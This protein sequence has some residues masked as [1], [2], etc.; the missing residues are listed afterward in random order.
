MI[1]VATG[2]HTS[3]ASR[4]YTAH[5]CMYFLSDSVDYTDDSAVALNGEL[6]CKSANDGNS[7]RRVKSGSFCLTRYFNKETD[8]KIG[9]TVSN[10][11]SVTLINDDGG[12]DNFDFTRRCK[13]YLNIVSGA[14]TYECPLGVFRF[15]KPV[16]QKTEFISVTGYDIMQELD[17]IA[18]SWWNSIDFTNGVTLSTLASSLATQVGMTLQTSGIVN[19]SESMTESPFTAVEMTYR[20]ILAM[21]CEAMG[22][23]G[24]IAPSGHL[25]LAGFETVSSSTFSIDV[26]TSPNGV[27]SIDI[28]EYSTPVIDKLRVLA[29][30]SA[31]SITIGSGTNTYDIVNNPFLFSATPADLSRKATAIYN[32]INGFSAYYPVSVKAAMDWSIEPGDI[33]SMTYG[34][35][36]YQTPIFQQTL[37]WNGGLVFIDFYCTGNA[38]RPAMDKMGRA[39]FRSDKTVHNIENTADNLKSRIDDFNGSGST[40]EQ[41]VNGI[42]TEVSSKVGDSEII[43]KIN[44]SAEEITINADKISLEGTVTVNNGFKI[45]Q[46]GYMTANGAT[47]NGTVTSN[48]T[49][50]GGTNTAEVSGG[51]FTFKRNNNT[52]METT[53]QTG[54]TG[55]ATYYYNSSGTL[56]VEIVGSGAPASGVTIYSPNGVG[57]S[58][59]GMDSLSVNNNGTG[60]KFSVDPS[61]I[62]LYDA[63]IEVIGDQ[64]AGAIHISPNLGSSSKAIIS[65]TD[66]YSPSATVVASM[67]ENGVV[68]ATS[69]FKLSGSSIVLKSYVD[70]TAANYTVGSS[71]YVAVNYPTGINPTNCVSIGM[72]SFSSVSGPI[73]LIPYGQVASDTKWYIIGDA[74]VTLTNVKFRYWY[75]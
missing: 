44:Q 51:A 42:N 37:T 56:I 38:F 5:V 32:K 21:L 53:Y 12:L 75:L 1:N 59:L 35:T 24:R 6:L 28:A 60:G 29:S 73:T 27:V 68:S 40:I 39:E 15:N 14:N 45:D 34:G 70:S 71:H 30:A 20:D 16:K 4:E 72:Y 69:D 25:R 66:S 54:V 33:V 9:D 19:G 13:V 23:N 48:A 3:A 74:G 47:V 22:V 10:A 41:T 26:D 62:D 17:V 63:D 43:S 67:D 57:S 36:T 55:I 11:L 7:D 2:F 31:D 61:G 58:S 18:D 50:N 49:M 8:Y 64:N 46:N 52:L 65:V